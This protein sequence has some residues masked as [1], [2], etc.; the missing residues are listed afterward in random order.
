MERFRQ[1]VEPGEQL[2]AE[3]P[4][5]PT[6]PNHLAWALATFPIAGA[7]DPLRAVTLARRAAELEPRN[8]MY[9]NT[10]GVALYRAGDWR[11]AIGMLGR[12]VPL[13]AHHASY[14]FFFLAM[15]HWQLGERDEARSWY[16]PPA[17]DGRASP[18]G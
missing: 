6:L 3:R 16:D 17:L 14:D 13:N 5:D 1:S 11:G 15:A 8:A 12:S 4:N 10:L 9:L 2:V 18:P 7:R